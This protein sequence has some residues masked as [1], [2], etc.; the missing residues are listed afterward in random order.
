M[1]QEIIKDYETVEK[2]R[3]IAVCDNCGR[4]DEES[5]MVTVAINPRKKL[6]EEKQLQLVKTFEDE[7]DAER[8]INEHQHPQMPQTDSNQYGVGWNYNERIIDMNASATA[9]VC[10]SCLTKLFDIDVDP[11]E[12]DDIDIRDGEMKINTTIE[13]TTIWPDI[14]E[15]GDTRYAAFHWG[16]KGR[17][18][19]WP[20]T[21]V[22]IIMDWGICLTERKKGYL[23]G[24]I[25]AFLWFSL[26]FAVL[27]ILL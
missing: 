20:F 11:E 1:A 15:W 8:F 23:A 26:L 7:Y 25:G 13:K 4:T 19:F 24:S 27:F 9:D 2:E 16:W 5:E 6:K 21:I 22:G 14:P 12:I 10:T 17:I 3:T 18:V